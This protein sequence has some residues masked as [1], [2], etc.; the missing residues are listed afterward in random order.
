M[1]E[2]TSALFEALFRLEEIR[3]ILRESAPKHNLNQEQKK[4]LKKEI[5]GIEKSLKQLEKL[6]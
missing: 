4:K 6:L 2:E 1:T 5:E 3:E